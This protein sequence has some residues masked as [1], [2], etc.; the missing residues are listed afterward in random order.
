M[1]AIKKK[2][3]LLVLFAV[4]VVSVSVLM[5]NS[6][7]ALAASAEADQFCWKYNGEV[8]E[9]NTLMIKR[10][11]TYAN[12]TL[13]QNGTQ[14]TDGGMSPSHQSEYV[15][16][17]NSSIYTPSTTPLSYSNASDQVVEWYKSDGSKV[18][19]D[20]ILK[21]IPSTEVKIGTS[22]AYGY[23]YNIYNVNRID[24]E[25]VTVTVQATNSHGDTQTLPVSLTSSSRYN[26]AFNQYGYFL[27]GTTNLQ[28]TSLQYSYNGK[29]ITYVNTDNLTFYSETKTQLIGYFASGN[30]YVT[31]PFQISNARELQNVEKI[32]TNIGGQAYVTSDFKLTSNIT[33]S[34][35][36]TPIP[37]ALIGTFDGNSK[38]ISNLTIDVSKAGGYY[39]LF[40]KIDSKGT[41]KNLNF[42]NVK[43]TS[44]V[45]SGSSYTRVGVIAGHN[46]GNISNCNAKGT[47]NIGLNTVYVG[48]I[49]GQ[50]SG[51]IE[52]C[53]VNETLN[54]G[55]NNVYVGGIAGYSGSSIKNCEAKGTINVALYNTYVGGIVGYSYYCKIYKCNNYVEITGSGNIGGIAGLVSY[56]SISECDNYA[57]ISYKYN[58][59]NG[60]AGGIVGLSQNSAS[61]IGCGNKGVIIY[62]S[63]I[64]NN[65]NIA[66]C[67][68]QIIGWNISGA[69]LTNC[70]IRVDDEATDYNNLREIKIDNKNTVNQARYCSKGAVGLT[71]AK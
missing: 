67:M 36:W 22:N 63:N 1:T 65:V 27:S 14:V 8:I 6:Q 39:G 70:S 49:V 15:T 29:S 69:P 32:K 37:Y 68:G 44:S 58:T 34:G 60:T 52:N 51:T 66:P 30:G 17:N 31:D 10:G 64:S 57:D 46:M 3:I 38:T 21:V 19:V 62:A 13:W 56:G 35:N 55:Q 24:G 53:E 26:I 7:T 45:T 59:Q 4:F 40:E 9:N 2:L 16:V 48:G 43:I 61:V 54:I 20:L 33:L 18:G 23:V 50:N 11:V 71:G 42:T 47:I 25:T 41:V 5:F 12:I 28:I